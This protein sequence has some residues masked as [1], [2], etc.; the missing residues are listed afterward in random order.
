MKN[1]STRN[2]RAF[3]IIEF[4]GV[5]SIVVIL[6]AVVAPSLLQSVVRKQRIS[7]ATHLA[8]IK[9][10][11][12][13]ASVRSHAIPDDVEWS[14]FV[15]DE[16]SVSP[17][18]VLQNVVGN[19]RVFIA[20]P[21]LVIDPIA[22]D[23]GLPFSQSPPGATEPQNLRFII[24]SSVGK[25]LPSLSGVSFD[26]LWEKPESGLPA[27]WPADWGGNPLDIKMVRIELGSLFHRIILN[28]LSLSSSA[29]WNLGGAAQTQSLPASTQVEFWIMDQSELSFYELDGINS[30]LS[31]IELI[32][33]DA[34]FVFDDG[35]WKRFLDSQLD[36]S[37]EDIFAD[38]VNEFL[39]AS[40]PPGS[41]EANAQA[42]VDALFEFSRGFDLLS[43]EG[44]FADNPY[45]NGP[46]EKLAQ[47]RIELLNALTRMK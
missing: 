2:Q 31:F 11:F 28:N 37:C 16:M 41:A 12:I 35:E 32:S 34:S 23:S 46:K 36:G 26:Q 7:E 43:R 17:G 45:W 9:D 13:A 39:T 47:T 33:E 15:A 4:V 24:L 6:A 1:Y 3:T 27:Q 30:E 20:D 38:L 21:T 19:T 8:N 40:T 44:G 5:L 29:E 25:A 18:Q 10:A 14:S 42:V 22:D